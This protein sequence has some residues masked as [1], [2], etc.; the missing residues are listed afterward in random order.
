MSRSLAAVLVAAVVL[1]ACAEDDVI[2]PGKR[3]SIRADGEAEAAGAQ[4]E[5]EARAIRLPAVQANASWPQ[6]YGTPAFRTENPA[7]GTQLTRIWSANIGA[8]DARRQRI[9]ASPVVGGGLIYTLDAEALV[10]ATSPNGQTVWQ[11]DLRPARD[12]GGQA[13]GGGL[14]YEDGRLY[15]TLGY[16]VLVS[17]DAISGNEVWRQSLGGTAS[18][19]PTVYQGLAYLTV[20]DDRGWAIST[21]DGRLQWQLIAS[22]DLT[23]V[24][25]APSPAVAGGLAVFAFGSGE[26]QAVFRQGGLRRWDA[27]ASGERP[28]TAL[29][30][31]G[32]VTASPVISGNRVYVGNQAGR[33]VALNLQSGERLWTAAEGAEGNILPVGGSVFVISDL[34]ELLRLDASD[35]SRIWGVRLPRFVNDRPTRRAEIVPHYGPILAGGRLYIASGDEQLRSFDPASGALLSAIEIP[36]GASSAPV[37][38]GGVLYVVSSK[39]QLHAFR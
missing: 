1:S 8:G 21:S 20:G 9:V 17:L 38:A 18:G 39:G 15:V 29:G 26:V 22:P 14:A 35:G 36:G 34:N 12:K 25:G 11:K 28:G 10:T 16:G 5:N 19:A 37:V 13:T 32:D 2:L 24:L 27:S 7:L 30:S 23:N 33:I 31:I 4:A 3:E 6:S